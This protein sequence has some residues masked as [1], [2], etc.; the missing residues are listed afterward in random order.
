MHVEE[1]PWQEKAACQAIALQV[2]REAN[3]AP[4]ELLYVVLS[5]QT[6]QMQWHIAGKETVNHFFFPP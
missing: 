6:P 3:L 4:L 5:T 2:M 1:Q